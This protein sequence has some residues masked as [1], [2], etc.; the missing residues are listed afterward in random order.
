MNYASKKV[1][2][3][4]HNLCP[5]LKLQPPLFQ[6]FRT[7][8]LNLTDSKLWV[9]TLPNSKQE[10]E[11]YSEYAV[12]WS[13]FPLPIAVRTF[14]LY[15]YRCFLDI[16]NSYSE[17]THLPYS[18][19]EKVLS[20]QLEILGKI[21]RK[22][23]V[24]VPQSFAPEGMSAWEQFVKFHPETEE[25][26]TLA[27]E[28]F[29]R[30]TGLDA[31]KILESSNYLYIRNIFIGPRKFTTTWNRLSREILSLFEE[32][33]FASDADRPG[34]YILE[35]LFSVYVTQFEKNS[36]FQTRNLIYFH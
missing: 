1:V 16:S 4:S 19:L 34:G 18:E 31:R 20:E 24:A 25:D 15:H 13:Q 21:R 35:R 11:L 36:N 26:L 6:I 17:T 14:G 2:V 29:F 9:S 7:S 28:L 33:G 32:T 22:I 5:E 27:C 3:A 30:L 10:P 12:F 8:N 23:V